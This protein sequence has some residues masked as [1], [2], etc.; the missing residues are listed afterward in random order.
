[1]SAGTGVR[2]SRRSQRAA[3]LTRPVGRRVRLL[4]SAAVAVLVISGAADL[5]LAGQLH[6]LGAT[7]APESLLAAVTAGVGLVLAIKRPRNAVGW[8]L[9][10]LV[11]TVFVTGAA[12]SYV[13]LDYRH[14]G[15]NWPLGDAAVLLEQV[16][17]L[18]LV[19][20]ATTLLVFPEGRPSTRGARRLLGALLT[21]GTLLL[22][23]ICAH[24]AVVAAGHRFHVDATGNIVGPGAN[25]AVGNA[26]VLGLFLALAGVVVFWVVQQVPRYRRA[27]RD[28]RAQLK[29]LYS[30]TVISLACGLP[31]FVGG[32]S[33]KPEALLV[34]LY[35]GAGALPVCI[36]VAVL[37]FRLY[38]IDRI[39]SRTISWALITAT[40]I[41]TYAG[42][43][44]LATKVIG[45]SSPVAVAASTLVAAALFNPLRRRV[46]RGVDRRFNRARYDAELTVAAFSTALRTSIGL[47][48]VHDELLE[49]VRRAVEPSG[50]AVLVRRGEQFRSMSATTA[51]AAVSGA[52][53]SLRSR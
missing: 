31:I 6:L 8:C 25:N 1:M 48:T 36:G 19:L 28:E 13:L 53:G 30:G 14:H 12:T 7:T 4:A 3:G 16:W 41:G 15:G 24:Y 34:A 50:C 49:T 9:L 22:L 20:T 2:H 39:V 5:V 42:I 17:E 47:Q 26:I 11:E 44:T 35:L 52:P 10:G 43:V 21:A 23:V 45:F 37:R 27:G 46:Q 33:N 32:S 38:E 29:W 51:G 18:T 40:V